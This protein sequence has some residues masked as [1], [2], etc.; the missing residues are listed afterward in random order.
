MSKSSSSL[1]VSLVLGAGLS[2]SAALAS[3]IGVLETPTAG[4]TVSGVVLVSG[5]AL[6]FAGIDKIELWV[7]D[8]VRSR[9]ETNIPRPD[10]I[11]LNP[12]YAGSPT[13]NPGFVTSFNARSL[14]VGPHTVAIKVSE[15]GTAKVFDLATVSVVVAVAGANQTPF[16]NIDSPSES[17]TGISGSFPVFGW[18]VDDSGSIDH[19]D[20]LVDGRIVAGAVGT[21][22]PSTGIYGLPRPD[23]FAL[24]PDVPNS[25]N[26]GFLANIDTTAFVDGVH[27][28]SV[29]AFDN[30]GS[31]N[32]IGTRTVQIINNGS[33]LPPFGFLDVPLDKASILC[34]P[35]VPSTCTPEAPAPPPG[36]G[37]C[38]SPCFP[39]PPTGAP[40]VPVSFYKNVVAGWALDV[41]SRRDL[42]QVSYVEL[43]IDGAIIANSRRDC[44]RASTVLANCYGVNRP[45]VARAYPGY[46]NADNSGFLFLFALQ[47]DPGNGLFDV[48]IPGP[49]GE[50]TCVG[51]VASGKHTIAIRAGD[52]KET[53]TQFAAISVDVLC[54]TGEFSDR[55]AFGYIDTP[56]QL[57]F[58]KGVFT[59]SGW[60]FDY[61][62]GGDA[63]NVN[64]ITRLD[65]DIDGQVVGSIPP[66]PL[67]LASRPD[68]PAN[69]FRVP[70]TDTVDGPTAF[71]GWS[72]AFD[73]TTLSDT[74]HDLVVYAWDTPDAASGRPSFRSEIGRRK[75]VVFN[76][77]FPKD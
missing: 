47:Q 36:P 13:H 27:I 67:P 35:V 49:F 46:V 37:P 60:A 62:N 18:V 71:V 44:V 55:P 12:S 51:L 19:I 75:F 73:T 58:V 42:G 25:H 11:A 24:F 34:G 32:V 8:A 59:F 28:I 26:S 17:Q 15:T 77:V 48:L 30:Q 21:G 61:D 39:P 45:D 76:N 43:L 3:P 64:G 2:G 10:V 6:D 22:L 14:P 63:S 50:P 4:Q 66:P 23:V 29:R 69:D 1:L 52:E 41:G 74:Q 72:F 68:V 20:F 70:A 33:N 54:D 53:V 57:Q 16:G 38:P 9:A 56:S 65:I 40:P 5:W 31:S 7:D